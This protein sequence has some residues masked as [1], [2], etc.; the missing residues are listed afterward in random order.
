MMA[1]SSIGVAS[2]S[3]SVMGSAAVGVGSVA[4]R[5]MSL[6]KRWRRSHEEDH[7]D[8]AVMW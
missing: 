5:T 8:G 4:L 3:A 7:V 2:S 6:M 1:A